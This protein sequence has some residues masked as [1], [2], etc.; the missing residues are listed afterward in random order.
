ML[1]VSGTCFRSSWITLSVKW[2]ERWD[3]DLPPVFG[4]ALSIGTKSLRPSVPK[5]RHFLQHENL[6]I[7]IL[8][9]VGR[10]DLVLIWGTGGV[11]H[12]P[13][14]PCCRQSGH[15][16]TWHQRCQK[17]LSEPP[18]RC[19]SG[20]TGWGWAPH[21]GM[22]RSLFSPLPGLIMSRWMWRLSSNVELGCVPSVL[23]CWPTFVPVWE[24]A[25]QH[26]EAVHH[27]I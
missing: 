24:D 13:W 2:V 18:L 4:G 11:C 12:G 8:G 21:S 7:C 26:L 23:C 20:Q 14:L 17:C 3:L 10:R 5:I 6:K 22:G 16:Q 19:L 15:T 27:V 1:H 25:D 9:T